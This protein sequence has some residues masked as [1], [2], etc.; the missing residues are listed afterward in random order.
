MAVAAPARE[1][2]FIGG[3]WVE[4]ADGRTFDVETPAKRGQVIAQV[5]RGG[6]AD[7]DRAVKAAQAAFPAW[8]AMPPRERGRLLLRIADAVDAETE[9]LAKLLARETGNA[10]RTQSRPEAQ[11]V[12][13]LFR[14]FGGLGGELKGETIPLGED[15]F[16]YTRRE[17]LGVVAA[18][19]P[20]NVPILIAAWKLAPALVAGNTVVLKPSANAPLATLAFARIAQ[21]HLPKGVLNVITGTG[22]EVGTPL[23]EHPGI[24]KISFTGNTET[25]KAILRLAADRI[26]PVTLELGGKS[27]QILFADADGD[28]TADGVIDAMRFAR[29]GQSCTAGSRLFVHNSVFDSFMDRLATKL[30]KLKVGDPL[31]ETNDMGAI[32]S[33]QQF[34]RVVSF[35]DEGAR[36]PGART[37]TGGHP[38]SDGPLASGYY[39]EP[40]VF[41]NVRNDWRIAKEEIFG[42]VLVAIPFSDAADAIR[43]ANDTHYGLAAY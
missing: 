9:E 11:R 19:V 22:D 26:I 43:M 13:D 25:G 10:I 2:M 42:P 17:P 31:D 41:A 4:S 21:R 34:E 1:K 5:P 18:I 15:W 24:A 37:V 33:K 40:T 32:V 27:P 23:A 20:W 29:Q 30:R 28:K 39:V 3:E 6:A 35:I 8:R 12:S 38:P 7:V 36:Q 14:Y 16:S